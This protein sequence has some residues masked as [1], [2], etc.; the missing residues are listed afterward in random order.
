MVNLER[1][2]VLYIVEHLEDLIVLWRFPITIN[3]AFNARNYTN[4]IICVITA[5]YNQKTGNRNVEIRK[6]KNRQMK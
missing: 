5:L 2:H 1:G 6:E 3:I 4:I